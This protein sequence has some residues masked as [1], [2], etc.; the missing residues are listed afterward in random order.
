MSRALVL[1][2]IFFTEK[3]AIAFL[4]EMEWKKKKIRGRTPGNPFLSM[5]CIWFDQDR[6]SLK[7]IDT[8]KDCNRMLLSIFPDIFY[9][10]SQAYTKG[11]SSCPFEQF[12]CCTFLDVFSQFK[13]APEL[14]QCPTA[15]DLFL[16]PKKY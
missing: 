2:V 3:D 1:N 6:F 14:P 7:S 13:M 11:D 4:E 10:R 16:Y 12:S 9:P 5:T 8:S 15:W